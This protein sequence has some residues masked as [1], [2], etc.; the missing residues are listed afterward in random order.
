V[1]LFVLIDAETG[2]PRLSHQ[3]PDTDRPGG[4]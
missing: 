3:Y 4:L 2:L 1:L